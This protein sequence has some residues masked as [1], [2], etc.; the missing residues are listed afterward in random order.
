MRSDAAPRPSLV[1]LV[2]FLGAAAG[3]GRLL[4]LSLA[5]LAFAAAVILVA[6]TLRGKPVPRGSLRDF[7][8]AAVDVA[9]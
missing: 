9:V 1:A 4:H 8:A 3:T 2:T 6:S 7:V 5:A